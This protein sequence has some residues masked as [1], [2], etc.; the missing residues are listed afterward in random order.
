MATMSISTYIHFHIGIG[1][2]GVACGA[3]AMALR[4]PDFFGLMDAVPA[5][6]AVMIRFLH[7]L[8]GGAF[9]VFCL[10]MPITANWIWPRYGTPT[11]I[12][13]LIISM[14]VAI[15][16]GI[17]SIR[18]HRILSLKEKENGR[19]IVHSELGDEAQVENNEETPVQESRTLQMISSRCMLLFCLKYGHAIFMVYSWVMLLGAGMAF[20]S[21]ARVNGFPYIPGTVTDSLVGRCYGRNLVMPE[22]P[23]WLANLTCGFGVI[24]VDKS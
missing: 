18:L 11:E 22:T 19:A 3:V 23:G 6:L 14:Y 16:G 1:W 4:I 8:L 15:V 2:T 24:C 12:I 5:K 9:L 13:Y 7:G 20:L 17:A 10:F 21:N